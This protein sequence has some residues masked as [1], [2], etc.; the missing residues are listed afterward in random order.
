MKKFLAILLTIATLISLLVAC[1]ES[2]PAEQPTGAVSET[3][4]VLQLD[5]VPADLKFD[6]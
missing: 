2:D 5:N 6:G 1:A 4:E 3:E